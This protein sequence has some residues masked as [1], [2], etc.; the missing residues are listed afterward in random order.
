[1]KIKR[2]H[3]TDPGCQNSFFQCG[4]LG[5]MVRTGTHMPLQRLKHVN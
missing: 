3:L 2:I 1:M 4:T 5:G